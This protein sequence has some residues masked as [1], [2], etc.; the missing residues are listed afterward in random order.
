[1]A[2]IFKSIAKHSAI[3]GIGDIL[4]KAVGFL[5]LPLYTNY[6]SSAEYGTL[7]LLGLTSFFISLFFGA[8]ISHS[9]S[10]FYYQFKDKP[11]KDKV[12]SNAFVCVWVA[13]TLSLFI[14]TPFTDFISQIVFETTKFDA[15]LKLVLF[16]TVFQL[17]NEIGLTLLRVR[18]RSGSFVLLNLARLIVSLS[19]NVYFVAF[20]QIGIVGILMSSLISATMVC[21]VLLIY[22]LRS[23]EGKIDLKIL[24]EMIAYGAP[25]IFGGL[26][27]L[28]LHFAD[29]FLLQRFT[30]LADVGV[31][32]LAYKFGMLPNIFIVTPFMRYW[33]V[34]QHDLGSEEESRKTITSVFTYFCLLNSFVGLGIACLVGDV[35]KLIS[36]SSYHG[37][38]SIAPLLVVAYLIAGSYH[39]LSYGILYSKKT[40]FVAFANTFAAVINIALNLF[41]IPRYG[42]LGASIATFLSFITL[43]GGTHLF[44]QKQ[45]HISYEYDRIAKLFISFLVI[46][47][48]S[49][50]IDTGHNSLN[51]ILKTCI[52]LLYPLALYFLGF[53]KDEE[54]NFIKET[55]I[56]LIKKKVS[57]FQKK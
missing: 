5:L 31:Y 46:L 30:S 45:F 26:S 12:V 32:A 21:A 25:L 27:M 57:F 11:S 55:S 49:L 35:I 41:L 6:L 38:A 10:R 54:L 14:L 19:L 16:T 2:N 44:S 56:P 42:V 28:S 15:F 7:E 50:L 24:K 23:I 36:D 43:V 18:E 29:R 17:S 22:A 4:S 47:C 13:G 20:Q 53:F 48:A 39:I 51:I 9:I 52:A 1:M 8:G 3:Y 40:K 37:A 33:G 34:K